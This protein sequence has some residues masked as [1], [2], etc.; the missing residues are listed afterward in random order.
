M[1][2]RA[3]GSGDPRTVVVPGLGATA[4]EARIPASGLPGTRIVLTL[5]GHVD[6][7]PAPAEYWT[8][9]SIAADIA[10]VVRTARRAIGVSLGAGALCAL[11]ADEPDIL[12]RLVLMLPAVL[13]KPRP[14]G[15][16]AVV[17]DMAAAAD[18]G[19]R[20]RLRAL[21][22]ETSP[23]GPAAYIEERTTALLRLGPALRAASGQLAV[24][25][26]VTLDRVTAD[27]LVIAATGD[28]LHP[29]EVAEEVAAAFPRARLARFDSA[30][31]LVTHRDD[32][33]VLVR[34]FLDHERR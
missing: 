22:A 10:P 9:P 32:V 12:D 5:P 20:D 6:A 16:A 30:A 33:R 23:V 2:S 24:T 8:Y 19:D 18:S 4:G 7:P 31:P 27:V 14:T 28:R 26:P 15:A 34:D 17:L 3:Y 11:V 13:A 29:S 21:V 25:D 1:I